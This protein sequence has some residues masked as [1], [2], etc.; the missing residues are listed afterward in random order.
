MKSCEE[1]ARE[2][3]HKSIPK[4]IREARNEVLEEVA[5][6]ARQH[7]KTGAPGWEIAAGIRKLKEKP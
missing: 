1:W 3:W 5:V 2:A 6:Y 4:V 7:C